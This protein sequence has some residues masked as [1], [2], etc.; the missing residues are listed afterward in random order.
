VI[1]QVVA[2]GAAFVCM[3]P[4]T[5]GVHRWVMHG[6]GWVL[7]R[8]HHQSR[9]GERGLEANDAYP[10]LFA[11]ST[12]AVMALGSRVPALRLL[13]GVGVGVTAYGAAYAFVHDVIIHRRI[14]PS[15]G[16]SGRLV[17]LARLRDAHGVHH[18]FGGAPYGMLWPVVPAERRVAAA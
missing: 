9:P 15:L 17:R 14:R 18:R 1:A 2:A 12:V 6:P 16:A 8:S 11:G 10:V 4:V 5:C 3:E 13:L 7:H